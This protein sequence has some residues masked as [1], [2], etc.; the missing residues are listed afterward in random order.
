MDDRSN[1]Y[2]PAPPATAE[3]PAPDQPTFIPDAAT[4]AA[5][6]APGYP[7]TNPGQPTYPGYPPAQPAAP[8]TPAYP[9][10]QGGAPM[11]SSPEYP[12]YAAYPGQPSA[13]LGYPPYQGAPSAPMGGYPQYQG[14]PSTPLQGGETPTMQS[15]YPPTIPAT[16]SMPLGGM[17]GYPGYPP[18]PNFPQPPLPKENKLTQPFSTRLTAAIA[19]A[20]LVL[21]L[22]TYAVEVMLAHSDWAGGAQIAGFVAIAL[23]VLAGIGLLARIVAGRRA[24]ST[25]GLGVLLA[26]VLA[27]AGA[28]GITFSGPL[29]K[30]Q[31][32]AQEGSH[33]W[34]A[35]I[36]EYQKA[37][38]A[39][40]NA[41]DIARVYD[42]W[43]E[44]LL[45]NQDYK[46]ALGQFNVVT[47]QYGQS[48][49]TVARA[50]TDT[51]NTYSAWVKANKSD[52]P[53]ADALTFFQTY[54][55]SSSCSSACQSSVQSIEAQAHFQFGQ[56]YLAQQDYA[57]AIS[58]FETVTSQFA[59][60]SFAAQAH[61]AAAQALLSYGQQLKTSA[62][63]NALPIYQ[64]LASQYADT[65]QGQQA[66]TSLAAPVPV[67]GQFSGN[68]PAPITDVILAKTVDANSGYQSN[69]YNTSV[70]GS[71][72]FSFGGVAAGTYNILDR[73]G[74]NLYIVTRS[75]G[76]NYTVTVGQ[77]CSPDPITIHF[78]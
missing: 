67:T 29:H 12:G 7:P 15:Q 10:Y 43:G 28:G 71:G 21:V 68:V 19:G 6:T 1:E 63:S 18:Y 35:A 34:T 24:S 76:S 41:P 23:G 75:D 73:A 61:S 32:H 14:A 50:N 27:V 25:I 74:G 51:F 22:G 11:P 53:Y 5:S 13:P 48:G 8:S 4:N 45:Q 3:P 59:Q 49:D 58:Q 56:Q 55:A 2:Q 52:T 77:L 26:V 20:A 40:P 47:T 54:G 38:E 62:C 31:A 65:S 30:A 17:P 33:E 16:P 46:G 42:E 44:Q 9:P 57:D 70:D 36:T 37:G 39:A 69:D 64:K 66:K 72:K 78:A 60:S